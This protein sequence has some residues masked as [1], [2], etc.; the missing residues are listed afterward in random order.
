MRTFQLLTKTKLNKR[1]HPTQWQIHGGALSDLMKGMLTFGTIYAELRFALKSFCPA[2]ANA[3]LEEDRLAELLAAHERSCD[4][5]LV[6]LLVKLLGGAFDLVASMQMCC[7]PKGHPDYHACLAAVSLLEK[8]LE[9]VERGEIESL[10][11]S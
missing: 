1:A 7:P 10:L 8:E 6:E 5:D 3:M 4:R 2:I 11:R 9:L